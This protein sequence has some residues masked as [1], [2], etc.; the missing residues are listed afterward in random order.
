VDATKSSTATDFLA[1]V[2][3]PRE[4]IERMRQNLR[5]RDALKRLLEISKRLHDEKEQSK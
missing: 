1:N 4:I 2:P 5:E 3:P